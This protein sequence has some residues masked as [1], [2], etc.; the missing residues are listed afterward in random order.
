MGHNPLVHVAHAAK[1]GFLDRM[2]PPFRGSVQARTRCGLACLANPVPVDGVK[3]AGAQPQRDRRGDPGLR[4]RGR[5]G[6][7]LTAA[8]GAPDDEPG[9][10]L[11]AVLDAELAGPDGVRVVRLPAHVNLPAAMDV[12]AALDAELLDGVTVLVADLAATA[13]LSL[14]GLQALLLARAAAT[15]RGAELRLSAVQPPVLRYMALMGT[16]GMFPLYASVD[17]ARAM[18]QAEPPPP[19]AP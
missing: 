15:R 9:V 16:T 2:V 4:Q 5:R 17:E 8:A 11:L 6:S 12:R 19:P 10:R 1:A 7:A 14:E 18:P 3:A 13:A